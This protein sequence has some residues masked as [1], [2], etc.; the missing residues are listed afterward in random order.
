MTDKITPGFIFENFAYA[1]SFHDTDLIE[2]ILHFLSKHIFLFGYDNLLTFI[3][4]TF[5]RFRQSLKGAEIDSLFTFFNDHDEFSIYMYQSFP[6]IIQISTD[7][8]NSKFIDISIKHRFFHYLNQISSVYVPLMSGEDHSSQLLC[9]LIPY[10]FS[11]GSMNVK[12]EISFLLKNMV[13]D[14]ATAIFLLKSHILYPLSSYLDSSNVQLVIQILTPL[15]EYVSEDEDYESI[16]GLVNEM[17]ENEDPI[18][19][20]SND[21]LQTSEDQTNI[22]PEVE[23]GS[24]TENSNPESMESTD[25][26]KAIDEVVEFINE[27]YPHFPRAYDFCYKIYFR[28]RNE[29]DQLPEWQSQFKLLCKENA[30]RTYLASLSA[31]QI[32]SE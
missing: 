29:I 26:E 13:H 32:L 16:I 11:N 15:L 2:T 6:E 1:I 10:W 23:K 21:D 8:I 9:S 22:G 30:K 12:V 3:S 27:N 7:L 24:C 14:S 17:L 20:T 31:Y 19:D 18:G 25:L 5:F 4:S 28:H